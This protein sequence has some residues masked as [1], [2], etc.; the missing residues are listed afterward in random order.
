[1]RGRTSVTFTS[2]GISL[3][4]LHDIVVSSAAWAQATEPPDTICPV[5]EIWEVFVSPSLRCTPQ[6]ESK[7]ENRFRP[8]AVEHF[9]SGRGRGYTL[10]ILV[11]VYVFNF[12]DRQ[13]VTI[14]QEPIKAEF[15]LA[16]WQLGL[17]TGLA[18]ALFYTA[19]G[20]PIARYVDRTGV[21]VMVI[22]VSLAVWS[23]ATA[24]CGM[25]QNFVQL[26]LARSIVGVGEAGFTPP[27]MSLISSLYP[28]SERGFALG[29]Y[30]LGIPIG[31]MFGLA[32]GGWIGQQFGWRWALLIV[33]LPGL[34]LAVLVKMTVREPDRIV[35]A[36]PKKGERLFIPEIM[37]MLRKPAYRH[38]LIAG[39]M[40]AVIS[41]GTSVWT[42][43]FLARSHGMSMSE[44]GFAWGIVAGLAGA[45]GS[46]GGGKLIDVLGVRDLR[47][48][49]WAPMGAML[50]ALPVYL[51]ALSVEAGWLAL[52]LLVLPITV[53][54]M[55]VT[56]FMTLGQNLAPVWLRATVGAFGGLVLN[57]IGI[58]MGPLAIGAAS[59]YFAGVTGSTSEGLRYALMI[60]GLLYLVSAAHFYLASRTLV[61]D[62]GD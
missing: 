57:L 52:T 61:H 21:R 53:N 5:G 13:I 62:L 43:S 9:V 45:A 7:I 54:G 22:S 60:T 6:R 59:D 34:L 28:R 16:D 19:L 23:F 2:P 32:L 56:S 11:I 55:F 24:L 38:L 36:A 51:L 46:V 8:F 14:L 26:V 10:A 33:G 50:I 3:A 20:L 40:A 31:S 18:F 35:E 41:V 4:S 1:M 42:P 30:A 44:I 29:V 17:M 58:G 48:A 25:A 15:A 37:S 49:A 39:T 12:I 47:A 27:A